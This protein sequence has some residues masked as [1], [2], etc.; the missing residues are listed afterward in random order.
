MN[1]NCLKTGEV[2]FVVLEREIRAAKNTIHLTTFILSRDETGRRIVA[3]LAERARAGV[4][5]RLLLDAVGSLVSSRHFVNPIRCR[6]A[7]EVGRFMPV[8]AFFLPGNA[9]TS[10]NHRKMAIFDHTR[11]IVGGRNIGLEYMGPG[12][13]KKHAGRIL[14]PRIEGPAVALMNEV[15][16]AD[17]CFATRKPIDELRSEVPSHIAES[18]GT[19]ELQVVASGP[20]VPGDPLYEGIVA[21]IQEAEKSILIVTPYFIP[22]EVLLRSLTLKARAGREVTLV[23]ARS[24]SNHPVTDFPPGATTRE[25]WSRRGPSPPLS[26]RDA[27]QQSD[28]RR[29]QD[30]ALGFGQF[31]SAQPLC[32]FLRSEYSSYSRADVLAMKAWAS[33]LMSRCVKPKP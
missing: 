1:C 9:P 32:K 23:V 10:R 28:D 16:I 4:K 22:D 33:E 26:S 30:S 14:A 31:R 6:P 2:E 8:T 17:W 25:N 18:R 3:L 15:F 24:G 11:A 29:R 19:S 27:P 12:G 5:V 7:G 20:D 13:L 21:M